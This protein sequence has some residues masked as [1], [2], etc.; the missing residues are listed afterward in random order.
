MRVTH[1]LMSQQMNMNLQSALRR[2]HAKGDQISTGRRIQ[3][4]SDDPLAYEAAARLRH[5]TQQME[6]Y[7]RNV[8]DGV[9]WLGITET[10]LEQIGEG[11][12]RARELAVYGASDTLNAES[13]LALAAEIDQIHA[14]VLHIGNTRQGDR[15]LFGGDV[16]D[17]PPFPGGAAPSD[18]PGGGT[19]ATA[20][21][22]TSAFEVSPGVVVPIGV[23]GSEAIQPALDVLQAISDALKADDRTAIDEALGPFDEAFS[24]LIRWRTEVGSRH[25]RLE[26]MEARLLQDHANL[27]QLLSGKEDVDMAEAIMDLKTEEAAY[28]AALAVSARV[29]QPTLLDFLR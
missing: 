1:R 22:G 21:A 8:S 29:I 10:A 3:L 19:G 5:T 20:P 4:P 7:L 26:L 25:N 23:H 24:N 2:M 18:P 9:S 15:Y 13:R 12:Q 14:H 28:R 6:Q 27:R 17:R 16:V 11:M